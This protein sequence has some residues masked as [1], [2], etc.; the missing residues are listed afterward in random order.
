[1]DNKTKYVDDDY[2][3]VKTLF[4]LR[5]PALF[6]GLILGIGISFIT[7][8]FEEV[9]SSNVEVAF[10]LPFVVYVADSIGTQTESIYSRDLKSGR[11][12]FSNYL[13][14]EL[15]LGTIFGLTFGIIAG[16]VVL[17]WL[18]NSLLALSVSLAT[19]IAITTAPIIAL[20][21]TQTIQSM[22]KDPAAGSG[23][24]A[25]VI[26]DM[27]SVLIYGIVCSSIIL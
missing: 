14:K 13:K 16:M 18:G 9:L 24:I 26:Q 7:S 6:M 25:T 1:M 27:S 3:S 10:F 19:F 17:F 5:A 22:K 8:G 20:I 2:E 21:V 12:K 4:S 23:P 15:L 11:A